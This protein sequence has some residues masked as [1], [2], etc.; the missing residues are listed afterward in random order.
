MIRSVPLAVLLA[1][2]STRWAVAWS[3]VAFGLWHVLGTLGDLGGNA[4]TDSLSAVERAGSV[5]GVV[6]ATT[7]AG[8]IFAWTRLR[9]GSL[10]APWR[11]HV[12]FKWGDLRC[13]PRGCN[14]RAGLGRPWHWD[15]AGTIKVGGLSAVLVFSRWIDPGLDFFAVCAGRFEQGLT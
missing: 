11:I 3:S 2:V 15:H 10:V 13:R 7:I 6:L 14:L 8:V 9:S 5:A 1:C 4:A 12:A